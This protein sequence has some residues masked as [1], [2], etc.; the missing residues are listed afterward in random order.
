M[1]ETCLSLSSWAFFV[2]YCAKYQ[3]DPFTLEIIPSV[4]QED[5]IEVTVFFMTY[6]LCLAL[7]PYIGATPWKWTDHT[8]IGKENG[9]ER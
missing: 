6:S 9:R 2:W 4:Q 3:W 8:S 7:F 1:S 5:P